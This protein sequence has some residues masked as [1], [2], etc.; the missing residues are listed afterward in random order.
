MEALWLQFVQWLH[1][2]GMHVDS[3]TAH[4]MAEG[5]KH[6]TA[7]LDMPGMLALA[8][9]LGWASGFRLY[10]VVFLV[11]GMGALGWL[12]LPAGLT[13][14]QNPIV[15][16]V[17]GFLLVVEF[18]ADKVPWIDSLWDSINAFIR[19]PAGALL[20][21]G[22]FGA[23]NA[24]MALAHVPDP[25]LLIRTGGEMRISNFLLWQCAYS[26]LYFSDKWWPEFDERAL[27]AAIEEFGRR[28]RR[29]GKTSEQVTPA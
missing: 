26:E 21:A 22:V 27:D 1:S 14:L 13:V 20:A 10:A 17:S 11:G 12:P 15:L 3:G 24:S 16:F 2:V 29:F 9:A 7:S 6:M 25:D 28:E 5:A 19:V 23:D 18:F 4:D 8:A